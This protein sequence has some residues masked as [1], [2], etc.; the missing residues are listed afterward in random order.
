MYHHYRS[1]WLN[2]GIS[3]QIKADIILWL[4][5][6]QYVSLFWKFWSH[7]YPIQLNSVIFVYPHKNGFIFTY[8]LESAYS[9]F[10]VMFLLLVKQFSFINTIYYTYTCTV[11]N[12]AR[13]LDITEAI[14]RSKLQNAVGVKLCL[15][16]CLIFLKQNTSSKHLFINIL[17]WRQLQSMQMAYM[18]Y[19]CGCRC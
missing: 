15:P 16:F 12:E 4:S 6:I 2:G 5:D 13:E 10:N 8:A 9:S 11:W 19:F 17:K 3:K 14:I 1:P 7:I 18:A